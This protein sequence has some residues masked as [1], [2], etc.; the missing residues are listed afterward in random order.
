MQEVILFEAD[1]E[2]E[3]EAAGERHCIIRRAWG[4][5]GSGGKNAEHPNLRRVDWGYV[6]VA[7]TMHS[8]GRQD[9]IV[10]RVVAG[11]VGG[12]N[13]TVPRAELTAMK[14]V[15]KLRRKVLIRKQRISV[16]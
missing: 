16:H 4:T 10:T 1:L 9:M 3:S 6:Q 14:Q 11:S 7:E 5:D 13:K 12:A 2:Q 15:L 8:D